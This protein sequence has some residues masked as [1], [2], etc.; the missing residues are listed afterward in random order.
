MTDAT[1]S[2]SSHMVC[3]NISGTLPELQSGLGIFRNT[4]F[5]GLGWGVFFSCKLFISGFGGFPPRPFIR[6]CPWKPL[7]DFPL[8]LPSAPLYLY[9]TCSFMALYKFKLFNLPYLQALATL[10]DS[11]Q[12]RPSLLT[13][14][15]RVTLWVSSFLVPLSTLGEVKFR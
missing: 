6:F 8:H 15:I 14:T 7:G 4:K 2:E 3:D 9:T 11:I 1:G 5:C 10:L 13:T 12:C